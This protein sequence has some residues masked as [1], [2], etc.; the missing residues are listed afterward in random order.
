MMSE[1][2]ITTYVQDGEEYDVILQAAE[3]QRATE[4]DLQNIYVRS[5][6]SGQLIPLSNLIYLEEKAGPAS[7]NRYNRLRAV[8]L[9]ANLGEGYALG[10]ALK[11]LE[12]TVRNRTAGDRADRLQGRITRI[13]GGIR[14]PGVHLRHCPADRIPGAGRPVRELHSPLCDPAVGTAWPSPAPCWDC[15]LTGSTLNIYSQIGVVM[16]IGIAAKNGVLIVEFINQLRDAG[17][18]F[19]EAILEA[20]GIRLRPVIMTTISTV[21]GSVPLIV[22]SG[23]GSSGRN[24]LGIVIFAGVSLAT[25]LTLFIVPAF[26][27][28]LARRSG[29]PK[30][31]AR[32]LDELTELL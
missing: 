31:I 21:I 16:L 10:D 24:V 1:Q 5:E 27:K 13:Q 7:L 15:Y 3:D 14:Q 32:Q 19:E 11:F 26:Y 17:R 25:L 2:R 8:T 28:L 18:D 9:T 23:A 22:A 4:R 6:T 29:S 20:S 12:D 30:A